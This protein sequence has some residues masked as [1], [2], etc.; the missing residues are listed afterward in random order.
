M[1]MSVPTR[2]GERFSVI[3]ALEDSTRGLYLQSVGFTSRGAAQGFLLIAEGKRIPIQTNSLEEELVGG[4]KCRVRRRV[5]VGESAMTA[6]FYDVLE[7]RFENADERERIE[8]IA[9]EALL[10]L[11]P[12]PT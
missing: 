1:W 10:L 4:E 2:A 6:A 3:P 9:L 12:I 8:R 5:V 11:A 7:Y